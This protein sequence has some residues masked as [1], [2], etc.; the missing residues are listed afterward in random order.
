MPSARIAW[1]RPLAAWS[2]L[3]AQTIW[4]LLKRNLRQKNKNK[5]NKKDLTGVVKKRAEGEGNVI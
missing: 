1:G 4:M 3:S 2:V 5:G